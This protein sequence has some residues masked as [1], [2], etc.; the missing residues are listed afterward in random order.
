VL[1]TSFPSFLSLATDH[2]D[3]PRRSIFT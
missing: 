2:P 3:R 1:R